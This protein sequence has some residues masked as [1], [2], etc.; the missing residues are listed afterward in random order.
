MIF[1]NLTNYANIVIKMYFSSRSETSTTNENLCV[2][3]SF[4]YEYD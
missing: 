1:N 4:F 3:F 2:I